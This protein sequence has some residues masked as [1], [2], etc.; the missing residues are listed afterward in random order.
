MNADQTKYKDFLSSL[1]IASKLLQINSQSK[2]YTVC[3]SYNTLYNI[4]YIVAEEE[5]KCTYCI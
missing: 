3:L 1:Y 5:F 4:A 2:T